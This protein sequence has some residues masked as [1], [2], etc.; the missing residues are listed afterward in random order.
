MCWFRIHPKTKYDRERRPGR[1]L[2]KACRHD[3][4]LPGG[5]CL[6]GDAVSSRLSGHQRSQRRRKM[7]LLFSWSVTTRKEMFRLPYNQVGF[8]CDV[9]WIGCFVHPDANLGFCVNFLYNSLSRSNDDNFLPRTAMTITPTFATKNGATLVA[10]MINIWW[11]VWLC[12][13]QNVLL[14]HSIY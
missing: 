1:G 11:T 8:D 4:N 7:G 3:Q 10:A 2:A 9:C 13:H 5:T 14:I 6:R 12:F